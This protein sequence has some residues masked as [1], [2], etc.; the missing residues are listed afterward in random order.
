MSSLYARSPPRHA[1]PCRTASPGVR[2][3]RTGPTKN[4]PERACR[5]PPRVNLQ[6]AAALPA[7]QEI[8]RDPHRGVGAGELSPPKVAAGHANSDAPRS[9]ATFTALGCSDIIYRGC[10]RPPR[11]CGS[12]R[13]AGALSRSGAWHAAGH[14]SRTQAPGGL[15]FATADSSGLRAPG[16]RH[17]CHDLCAFRTEPQRARERSP[18]PEEQGGPVATCATDE[19]KSPEETRPRPALQRGCCQLA[20]KLVFPAT[21]SYFFWMPND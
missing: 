12:L 17:S 21:V 18:E 19:D 6:P 2:R 4:R 1:P 10:R 14:A 11:A 20:L 13:E 3:A 8:P 9:C 15:I 5:P 7:I 16:P